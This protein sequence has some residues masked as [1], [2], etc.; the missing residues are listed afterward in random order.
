MQNETCLRYAAVDGWLVVMNMRHEVII[1][2]GGWFFK[3]GLLAQAQ[4]QTSGW[5]SYSLS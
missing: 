5:H 1:V 3:P 4:H 2:E